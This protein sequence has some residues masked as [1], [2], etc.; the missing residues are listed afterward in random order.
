MKL[1]RLA[2]WG[3]LL[4]AASPIGPS[5]AA[6]GPRPPQM[7]VAHADPSLVP[8]GP[9]PLATPAPVPDLDATQPPPRSDGPTGAS[10]MPGISRPSL[11]PTLESQ[12]YTAGS[13]YTDAFDARF[14]PMPT[15]RL[16]VPLQ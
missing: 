5:R 13:S 16:S 10:L 2:L 4:L 11:G 9:P 12:G 3:A 14:H 6:T 7:A 1:R 15:L 8:D